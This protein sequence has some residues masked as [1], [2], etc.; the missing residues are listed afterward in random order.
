M[1]SN[2]LILC[3]PLLLLP[4]IFPSIR[5]FSKESSL[6]I[7]WPKYWS[8]SF[9]I[10]P[11]HEYSGLIS[12]RIDWFDLLAV[13]RTLKSPLQHH[14]L[15][16]SIIQHSAFFIIFFMVQLTHLYM[17]T[18]KTIALTLEPG[19][20]QSRGSQRVRHNWA[21]KHTVMHIPEK[22]WKVDKRKKILEEFWNLEESNGIGWAV[23]LQLL[24][25]GPVEQLKLQ[26]VLV[27]R[28]LCPWHFPGKNPGVGCHFLLQGIYL[29]QGSNPSLPQ[30]RQILYCQ[31]HQNSNRNPQSFRTEESENRVRGKHSCWKWKGNLGKEGYREGKP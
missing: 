18:R 26:C 29:T 23:Y 14:N 22:Y 7:R 11:S 10:T 6:R 15:K 5:V 16:A 28:F 27:A 4:L 8:F 12:F 31:S 2:H 17:T 24:A 19:G 3:C 20:L 21:T 1:P 9:S 30:C 25:L 13:Q